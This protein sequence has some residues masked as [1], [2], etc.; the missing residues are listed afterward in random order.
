MKSCNLWLDDVREPP[1]GWYWAKT[2]KEAASIMLSTPIEYASLDHDLGH[3]KYDGTW[4]VKWMIENDIW[5][6]HKPGVHSANLYAAQRMLGLI[7]Q[8]GP[9]V[10]R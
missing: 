8:F 9:Y 5:P 6:K 4:L 7:K 2:A 10:E 3:R 1:A